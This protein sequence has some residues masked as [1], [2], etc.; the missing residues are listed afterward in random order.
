MAAPSQI[1]LSGIADAMLSKQLPPLTWLRAFEAAGRLQ[2]FRGAALELHLSPSAVSHHIRSL[3]EHLAKPLFQRTGNSVILTLEGGVYLQEISAGFVRLTGAVEVFE[4]FEQHT[5]L[6]I[7]AFPFLVNE[8]LLPN[9]GELRE[10]LGGMDISVVSDTRLELLTVADPGKRVDAIIR[11]GNGKFPSCKSVKL[12]D[13]TL[14][15]VASPE[16]IGRFGADD[17]LRNGPCIVVTG[18]FNAWEVWAAGANV[19]FVKNRSA[20]NFDSYDTALQAAEHGLG[21][22]LGIRPFI[23]EW[24]KEGRLHIVKDHCVDA[25]QSSYLVTPRHDNLRPELA[26]CTSWLSNL[27]AQSS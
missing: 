25:G 10:L 16:L 8:W 19:E 27:F 6:T 11:Y 15:P 13:V 5:R 4:Q 14:V 26:L 1:F 2:S 12:T 20:L 21:V 24:L 3:E 7:G 17:L 9:L 18:P 23:D 22:A